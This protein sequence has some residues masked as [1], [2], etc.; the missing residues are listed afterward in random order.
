M[1]LVRAGRF[2]SGAAVSEAA[3]SEEGLT[4]GLRVVEAAFVGVDAGAAFEGEGCKGE[5]FEAAEVAVLPSAAVSVRAGRFDNCVRV[6]KG[7]RAARRR[8]CV[9]V[10]S[11]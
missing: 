1:L 9:E 8:R 5:G 4:M 11:E 2:D 3:E 7:N 10:N 6:L